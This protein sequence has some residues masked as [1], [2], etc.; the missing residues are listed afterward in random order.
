MRLF[1]EEMKKIWRPGILAAIVLIGAMFY[2][3]RPEFY[4]E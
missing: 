4:M 3:V 1:W 2:W